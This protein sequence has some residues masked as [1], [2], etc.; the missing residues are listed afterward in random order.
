MRNLSYIAPQ[1]I[2]CIK[3]ARSSCGWPGDFMSLRADDA[4]GLELLVGEVT[5]MYVIAE[6]QLQ[7]DCIIRP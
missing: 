5:N 2:T 7:A 3:I 1:S 4:V 6:K